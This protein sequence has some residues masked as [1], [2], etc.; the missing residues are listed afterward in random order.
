M[1]DDDPGLEAI[2]DPDTLAALDDH[3]LSPAAMLTETIS[4]EEVPE[5]FDRLVHQPDG[6]K[7]A[8]VP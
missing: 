3:S 7:V 4:L 2:Y 5:R 8:I 6:G 1:H